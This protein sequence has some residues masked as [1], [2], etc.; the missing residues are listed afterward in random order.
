MII[1][2]FSK[3]MSLMEQA[4]NLRSDRHQ[5][6]S[7]NIANQDTPG[8][9][10]KEIR[11]KEVMKTAKQSTS[12][13]PLKKTD[14]SHLSPLR[15]G[16][17]SVSSHAVESASTESNRLDGNTVNG[18]VEMVKLAENTMMYNATAQIIAS[19]F[20]GLKNIIREGR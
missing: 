13:I 10:S 12:K 18:E 6:I 20:Q 15:H 8:Y 3:T 16:F 1:N 5:V 14:A 7:G 17:G 4:L 2:L 9:Q 19:K 11:F